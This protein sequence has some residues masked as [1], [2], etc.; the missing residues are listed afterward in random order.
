MNIDAPRRLLQFAV[1]DAVGTSRPSNS[2]TEPTLKRLRSVVSLSTGDSPIADRPRRIQ[3]VARVPNPMAAVIR[4]VAEAAEDVTRVKSSGSVFD[5]LGRGM[6]VSENSG[7][8]ASFR[9]ASV[10]DDE[11]AE[12]DHTHKQTRAAYIQRSDHAGKYLGDMAMLENETGLPSDSTAENDG[13][14]DA[15]L[16]GHRITD[17]SQTGTSGGKNGENSLMVPYNVAKNVD[18]VMR[19]KWN[20]DEGQPANTSH[21]IVNISLNMNTWKPPP[22][23]EQR[24][25]VEV[26]GWKSGQ[27]GDGGASKP[28]MRA[29]KEN[30]NTVTV[31][32]NVRHFCIQRQN[33]MYIVLIICLPSYIFYLFLMVLN[34]CINVKQAK[35]AA[36]SQKLFQKI[37]SSSTGEF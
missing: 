15:N 11:F 33:K 10:V 24:E 20:R 17:A 34:C 31:N 32:G 8:L 13:Y 22:Y 25:V 30:S 12:V 18:D 29:T 21:K 6:D 27:E 7:Q 26:D 23:Q 4:A 37:V 28:G 36:D 1:R 3:S 5:R 35:P 16:M 14:D 19:V 9:E 2:V